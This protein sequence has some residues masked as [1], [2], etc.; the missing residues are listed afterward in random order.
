M[1]EN[2]NLN[3]FI[4]FVSV[5]VATATAKDKI[6]FAISIKMYNKRTSNF[7]M[8]TFQPLEMEFSV[9]IC[10]VGGSK[11]TSIWYGQ[12]P[13]RRARRTSSNNNYN[14][15]SFTF[16]SSDFPLWTAFCLFFHRQQL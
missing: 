16:F 3:I 2:Y 10:S 5:R 1:I 11:I 14:N 8:L 13:S 9:F 4:M 7:K 6:L 12:Q 15:I